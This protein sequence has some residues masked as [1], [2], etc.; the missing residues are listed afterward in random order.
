MKVLVLLTYLKIEF[1]KE[2]EEIIREQQLKFKRARYI[3]NQQGVPDFVRKRESSRRVQKKEKGKETVRNK[4][5][6]P[7]PR[8]LS[9][10]ALW[11]T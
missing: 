8:N 1:L 3:L 6:K 9:L 7:K 11:N 5:K 4:Q 10:N 2:F